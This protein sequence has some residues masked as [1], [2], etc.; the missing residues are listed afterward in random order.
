MAIGYRLGQPLAELRFAELEPRLV[1][2]RQQIGR[3]E[4][5]PSKEAA[6]FEAWVAGLRPRVGETT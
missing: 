1:T 2:A 6:A 4:G 3:V 5:Y